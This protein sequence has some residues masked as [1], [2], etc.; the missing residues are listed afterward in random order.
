M[1][2]T[3][4]VTE[5][6]V[7]IARRLTDILA[8]T[9]VADGAPPGHLHHAYTSAFE[10]GCGLLWNMGLATAADGAGPVAL[11]VSQG[12]PAYFKLMDDAA[13]R[14]TLS[15]E[16]LPTT[17]PLP[18]LLEAFIALACDYGADAARRLPHTRTP[19][20]P[21][22]VNAAVVDALAEH[23]YLDRVEGDR[24]TWSDNIAPVMVAAY[25]WDEDGQNL[26]ELAAAQVE[27][28]ARRALDTL[29][30]EISLTN[31]LALTDHLRH[32][33]TGRDWSGDGPPR[34]D[35]GHLIPLARRILSEAN[36]RPG[37]GIARHS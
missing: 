4:L 18:V 19:F 5:L 25:F 11:G 17:P 22:P 21:A 2:E 30:P 7:G 31:A 32:R 8:R 16:M 34:H 3:A 20:S 36:T 27:L 9:S 35:L 6:A 24:F 29:P 13:I 37:H 33:W 15:E 14:Q 1:S 23:G 26:S 12:I 10:Q 28:E